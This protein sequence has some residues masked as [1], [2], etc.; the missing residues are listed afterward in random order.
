MNS[1]IYLLFV[2]QIVA[3]L[4]YCLFTFIQIRCCDSKFLPYSRRYFNYSII[5]NIKQHSGQH[6]PIPFK[7]NLKFI[8]L[9]END[10][11]PFKLS[12]T[13]KMTTEAFKINIRLWSTLHLVSSSSHIH[14]IPEWNEYYRPCSSLGKLYNNYSCTYISIRDFETRGRI[15]LIPI[16]QQFSHS[17]F[18]DP[19]IKTIYFLIYVPTW[20]EI[21]LHHKPLHLISSSIQLPTTSSCSCNREL[22]SNSDC[23]RCL[24]SNGLLVNTTFGAVSLTILNFNPSIHCNM[25]ATHVVSQM[26]SH[27]TTVMQMNQSAYLKHLQA[28]DIFNYGIKEYILSQIYSR[29]DTTIKSVS[30]HK[31]LYANSSAYHSLSSMN[32]EVLNFITKYISILNAQI[33]CF[34]SDSCYGPVRCTDAYYSVS[35]PDDISKRLKFNYSDSYGKYSDWIKHFHPNNENEALILQRLHSMNIL[36]HL[37]YVLSTDL[38]QN[39][40]FINS[41]EFPTEQIIALMLTFWI[42]VIMPLVRGLRNYTKAQKR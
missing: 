37:V 30:Q 17:N 4:A 23:A 5:S 41:S 39:P 18:D 21:L 40:S 22:L 26:V 10:I 13:L 38:I 15:E 25:H 27:V 28:G 24:N 31:Q 19:S 36:S 9:V 16:L 34:E 6:P 35:F 8:F 12:E 20:Q 11:I 2:F 14:M 3:M 42:P 29:I 33:E 32:V 7:V 1:Q